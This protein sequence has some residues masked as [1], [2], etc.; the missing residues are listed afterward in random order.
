MLKKSQYY[1]VCLPIIIVLCTLF[2]PISMASTDVQLIETIPLEKSKSKLNIE[3]SLLVDK[4]LLSNTKYDLRN[5]IE[6]QIKDQRTTARMLVF[7][8]KY[9]IRN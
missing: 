2:T 4:T 1:K 7:C 9:S 5:N 8:S 3:N 6:V